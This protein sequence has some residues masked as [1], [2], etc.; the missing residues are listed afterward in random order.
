LTQAEALKPDAVLLAVGANDA[1]HFTPAAKLKAQ[2]TQIV[3]G[4]CQSNP[5]VKIVVTGCPQM[6][7]IPR[8]LQP[9]RWFAGTQTARINTVFAAI[10]AKENI[11]WAHIADKTG[12]AF[13]KHPALFA[14]DKFHPN[15]RGYALWLPVL[16]EALWEALSRSRTKE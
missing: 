14:F 6:G 8:F 7:S 4:L 11:V 5:N 10:Q 15:A 12:A 2:L 9:L 3:D 16:D 13:E 1:T